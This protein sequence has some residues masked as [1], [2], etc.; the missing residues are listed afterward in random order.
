MARRLIEAV[1]AAMLIGF[2]VAGYLGAR[3]YLW[4]MAEQIGV[5]LESGMIIGMLAAL[6]PGIAYAVLGWRALTWIRLDGFSAAF[7]SLLAIA[8]YGGYNAARPLLPALANETPATRALMGAIDGV[9]IGAIAGLIVGFLSGGTLEFT[10]VGLLRY[11][12]LF[13]LTLGV[14]ALMLF[15]GTISTVVSTFGLLLVVP[16]FLALRLM[17][18]TYDARMGQR[19]ES[20]YELPA[21]DDTP[22]KPRRRKKPSEDEL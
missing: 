16:V 18:R 19:S 12:A 3:S 9:L 8:L 17:V 10:R 13:M 5:A 6:I 4:G 7:G 20:S 14:F 1:A 21:S 15:M 11:I 2:I 22:A